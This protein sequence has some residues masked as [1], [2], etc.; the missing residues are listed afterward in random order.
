MS[1]SPGGPLKGVRVIELGTMI[2]GPFAA[3]LLADYGAEVIKIEQPGAGD[4]MRQI[5]PFVD[6]E[7]LFWNVEGRNKRSLTVDLRGSQGRDLLKELVGKADVLI[8]NFRPGTMERWGLSW[9]E[10]SKVNPRLV[11]CSISGFGQSG[12][13]SARPAYDRIAL[14]FSGILNV[15]GFPDG[16][17]V[18]PGIAIGD[19]GSGIFGAL[20]VMVALYHRDAKNGIGQHVDAAMFEAMFRLTDTM[21]PSYDKLGSIR[22]RTGNMNRSAAPGDQF[23]TAD[24]RYI[25]ITCSSDAV[26]ARLCEGMQRPDLLEDQRFFSHDARANNL[27]AING[28]VADWVRS[29]P[30]DEVCRRLEAAEQPHS[31]IYSIA[32]IATDPHYQARQSIVTVKHPRLG[33]LKMQGI[34]PCFTGTPPPPVRPAPELGADTDDILTNLLHKTAAEIA[35]FRELGVI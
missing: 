10:L 32:D 15:T 24:D 17:P 7:S 11:M 22:A 25:A 20:G 3:T 5:G 33:D 16:P 18:R 30:A 12:P 1:N 9:A 8:E 35:V 26:F 34:T 4:P 21:M 19:Y 29:L 2:A 27:A 14:A 6:G 13:Y 31:L 23:L 28:V